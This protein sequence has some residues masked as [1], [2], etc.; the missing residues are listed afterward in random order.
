MIN[1]MKKKEEIFFHFLRGKKKHFEF[2]I[3]PFKIDKVVDL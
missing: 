3:N 1:R 2:I